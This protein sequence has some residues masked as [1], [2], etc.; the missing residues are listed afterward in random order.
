MANQWTGAMALAVSAVAAAAVAHTGA[1]GVVL[2]RMNGMTAMRD[3]VAELAPMMQG[4]VPYDAFIVSEGAS[5]IAAHA[6][7]MLSLFP[8][9][10]LAGVTYAKPEIWSNWQDFAALAEEMKLYADALSETASNGLEPA[11]APPAEMAGM[12]H[13]GMAMPAGG[14]TTRGFSVAELMG[15][16]EKTV[17]SP[18]SRGQADPASLTLTLSSLAAG[19]LFTRIGGTCSSCHAQFRMGR[20]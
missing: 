5:V 9:G 10:S 4:A 13:A 18:V 19:D 8:E 7:T 12:D 2:E 14:E 16:D 3:T 17:E 6:A 15:Y 20:N 1:S 11:A